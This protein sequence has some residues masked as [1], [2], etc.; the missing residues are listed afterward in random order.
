MPLLRILLLLFSLE[1]FAV[2]SYLTFP[3]DIDWATQKSEHFQIIFRRGEERF[4][5]R[6]LLAAE[7]A[8]R[9]LTPIFPDTPKKTW[10]VLGDFQDSTNGYALTFPYPHIVI[11]AAPPDAPGQL[12]ALDDWLSSVVLHELVHIL[13]VYPANGVWAPLRAVF[14]SIISPNGLMPSHF[15]EGLAVFLETDKTDGGRGKSAIFGAFRRMAVEEKVWGTEDFFSLDQMDGAPTRYPQGTTPYFFGYYLY[16]ELWKRKGKEGINLLVSDYSRNWPF[17]LNGPLQKVYDT[18]YQDLW[19]DI[20]ARTTRETEVEN[21]KIKESGL[22]ELHYLTETRQGKWDLALTADKKRLAYRDWSPKDGGSIRVVSYPGLEAIEKIETTTGADGMCWMGDLLFYIDGETKNQYALNHVRY[23]DFTTKKSEKVELEKTSLE[24]I[25]SLACSEKFEAI[26]VYQEHGG[27]GQ[28]H[29]VLRAID[30]KWKLERSFDLPESTWVSG[31]HFSGDAIRFFLR[32]GMGT[33]AYWWTKGA[34]Q[35][36]T[37]FKGHLFQTRGVGDGD[38]MAIAQFDGRSEIWRIDWKKLEA[39]KQ[40][41]LLGGAASFDM[42]SDGM[43]LSSYRHGGYDIATTTPAPRK[44]M[45]LAQMG[46]ARQIAESPA[47]KTSLSAVESYSPLETMFPRT[48]IPSM[49]FVPD[50]IQFGVYVPAFDVSQKHFFELFGGYDTRGLPFGSLGYSYRFAKNFSLSNDLYYLPNYLIA[51]REFFKRWGGSILFGGSIDPIPPSFTIGPVFRRIEPLGTLPANQSVGVQVGLSYRLGY[52]RRPMTIAPVRG[53]GLGVSWSKFFTALGSTDNY[54]STV[55]SVEQYLEAPWADGHIFYGLAKFGYTEGTAF[56][57]NYFDAGGEVIFSQGRGAFL[58]RGF[59]PGTFF[60]RRIFNFNL[61]Y[62][63][64]IK[65]VYRGYELWP[66][67]LKNI[68]AS[69]VADTTS[70]DFGNPGINK[71]DV[72]RTFYTSAGL[73]LRS[74]WQL[75][76]Y[77]PTHIRAGVYRGFGTYGEPFYFVLG[78]EA[79]L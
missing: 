64:P 58:N 29:E 78:V 17:L 6:T 38:T 33:E 65:R 7:R 69:L 66:L 18:T 59:L 50:G 49:L 23:Y 57:V 52:K 24:H 3:P 46:Q 42:A 14:G 16:E 4:G 10:I 73:E 40:V 76:F 79:A 45:R 20:F 77:L 21:Q 47:E 74:D 25:H 12:A 61:E 34:P 71:D 15:H 44:T 54:S 63:F 27:K 55:A 41:S 9:T 72:F 5:E 53:T 13:H 28:V 56:Y 60:G 26:A 67:Y 31:L 19:K 1:A 30:K 32:K 48:W 75:G 51:T 70:L 39:T 37:Q 2:P 36:I 22:S 68:W 35:K 11:F 8:W 43:V 62:R